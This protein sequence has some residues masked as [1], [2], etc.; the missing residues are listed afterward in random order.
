MRLSELID[1]YKGTQD[2]DILGL[3][4]DSRQVRPGSLFAALPGLAFNGADFI[5]DAVDNGAV[6]VLA[7]AESATATTISALDDRKV[8]LIRAENPRLCF[9]Q[10]ASRFYPQQPPVIAAVTGTNGK[11]SVVSFTRQI[12]Q[13]LGIEAASLGTVGLMMGDVGDNPDSEN[14][15]STHTTPDPVALHQT[16]AGLAAQNI[17]CLA[18]EAS[19]HGLDQY[20]LDGVRVGIA[21]FTNLSRDHLDYHGSERAY[22]LAKIRLFRDILAE[23][24]VAVLNADAEFYPEIMGLCRRRNIRVISVG[25]TPSDNFGASQRSGPQMD[26][27]LIGREMCARG[28]RIIVT[29]ENIVYNIVLPLVGDFQAMNALMAAAI[30]IASGQKPGV[31]F[32][33]L[34]NL[35]GVAGRMQFAA[36]HPSGAQVFVDY[37]H[38]PD[39]LTNALKALRPHAS[40]RL[41]LVFGCGGDRDAGKRPQMGRVADELADR[42]IITDDNPRSEVP[43]EIRRHILSSCPRGVAI[44][45]RGDAIRSAVGELEE[46]DLLLIA[47]KGH[48]TGQ[49]IG[50]QTLPFDDVAVARQAVAACEQ[51]R[52]S[53][54]EVGNGSGTS[55]G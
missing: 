16:L 2:P 27:R 18:L 40:G 50:S 4:A 29:C 39:A 10:M 46:G 1:D 11:T 24:G 54:G 37:A 25:G 55:N 26:I 23:R 47:G 45:D 30:V 43:S 14:L 41:F 31:V 52:Q 51:E 33:E 53:S 17:E 13:V 7:G 19:S 21:A 15:G 38:T 8:D 28:Q 5:G 35:V 44:G 49:I 3:T 48:E 32:K 12:W 36:R 20:R 22:L 9:A 42:I 34:E 6:A